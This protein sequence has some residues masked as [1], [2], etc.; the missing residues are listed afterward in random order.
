MGA[1]LSLAQNAGYEIFLTLDQ[2]LEHEQNLKRAQ[3]RCR[4]NQRK[5]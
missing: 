4:R 5:V 1:L 2:G 3:D